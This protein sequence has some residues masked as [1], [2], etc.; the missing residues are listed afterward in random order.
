MEWHWPH[1][2]FG[3]AHIIVSYLRWFLYIFFLL[4]VKVDL[5]INHKQNSI[6]PN[7]IFSSVIYTVNKRGKGMTFNSLLQVRHF[8][9]RIDVNNKSF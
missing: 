3:T 6:L 4:F 5:T 7:M 2:V 8:N 1:P 9:P